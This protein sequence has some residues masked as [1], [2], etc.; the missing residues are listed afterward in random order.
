M[1]AI[2]VSVVTEYQHGW[3]PVQRAIRNQLSSAFSGFHAAPALLPHDAHPK[4]HLQPAT[5]RGTCFVASGGPSNGAPN[6]SIRCD[7]L[8]VL[9][10][11]AQAFCVFL[12][13]T[14]CSVLTS[15]C[16]GPAGP[17]LGLSSASTMHDAET[18]TQDAQQAGRPDGALH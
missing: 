3:K 15:Y 13:A 2:P 4:S 9:F 12:L 1:A 7:S 11:R 10:Q 14:E 8:L 5:G 18:E 17:R 6:L 16:E